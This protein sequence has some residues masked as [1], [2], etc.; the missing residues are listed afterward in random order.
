MRNRARGFAL[1]CVFGLLL[2]A[3]RQ[4]WPANTI[5]KTHVRCETLYAPSA[6]IAATDDINSIWRAPAAVTITNIWCESPVSTVTVNLQRDDGS[7]VDIATVDLVC[8]S[9]PFDA[10]ASG[11][12]TTLVAAEDSL[13]DGER[14]DLDVDSIGTDP[15]TLNICWEYTYD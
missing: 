9:T 8:A 12:T 15:T 13:A 5:I 1:L 2:M 4:Q 11:C 7:P 6:Y 3:P 14:I 10:C